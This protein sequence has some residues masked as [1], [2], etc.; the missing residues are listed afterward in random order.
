MDN[1]L[2]LILIELRRVLIDKLIVLFF[3]GITGR[4]F[5]AFTLGMICTILI[6][7]IVE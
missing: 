1:L 3:E 2:N 6:Q 5:M 7:G 4:E